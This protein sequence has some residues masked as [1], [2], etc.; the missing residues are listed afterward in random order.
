MKGKFSD[1][2][3]SERARKIYETSFGKTIEW[4]YTTRTKSISLTGKECALNCAHCNKQWLKVMSFSKSVGKGT[5]SC[6]IS[7]GCDAH[8]KVPL[9]E[10]VDLLKELSAKTRLVA[11]SGLISEE[12]AKKIAPFIDS[13]SFNFVGDNETISDVL[14]L[15]KTVDDFVM[16]YLA[17]KKWTKVYPHITVGLHG[18]EI[19]GEYRA[20]KLLKGLGAEMIVFNVLV[21]TLNTKYENREPPAIEGVVKLV[22]YARTEFPKAPFA[23]G[24]MRPGGSYRNGLD[25]SMVG[26]VNRIVR[27]APS[28][29]ARAKELGYKT[30]RFDECCIL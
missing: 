2:C 17:L 14:G 26:I 29:I 3:E 7:G 1:S 22:S 20:L 10:N 12:D 23:I 15:D 18:G 16:A 28:A 9:A 6:L 13:V 24:C 8:G 27:P 5:K 19:G 21:P 11:H 30:E 4:V 25:A